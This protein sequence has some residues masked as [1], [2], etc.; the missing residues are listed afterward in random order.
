[1]KTPEE[2]EALREEYRALSHA[3]QSG[4]AVDQARGSEDG[5]PKHL[6]VGVNVALVDGASLVKLLMDK[7]IFTEEEHL[8]AV[9]EGMRAEVH[10]YQRALS[11]RYG[12]HVTLA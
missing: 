10:R 9:V 7:G 12:L 1:M 3:M 5:S 4:V 2:L 11:D 8:V 6:R